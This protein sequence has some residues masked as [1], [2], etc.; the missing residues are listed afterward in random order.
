MLVSQ[1]LPVLI[2]GVAAVL[3]GWVWYSPALFGSVWMRMINMSPEMAERGKKRMPLSALAALISTMLV[4]WFLSYIGTVLGVY[5]W[6]G[7]MLLGFWC[8]LGFT[9]PPML[10]MVL[11]EMKPVRYYLI[12]AGYW[13][14]SFVVMA[15]IVTLGSQFFYTSTTVGSGTYA[16][17]TE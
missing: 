13:L 3:L 6:L 1:L 2:A 7:A 4:A 15:L 10:G 14:V 5:D 11:W 9:A 8:W 17:V 16:P 12:V